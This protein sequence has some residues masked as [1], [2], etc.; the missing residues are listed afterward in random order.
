MKVGGTQWDLNIQ[1]WGDNS[2]VCR[3]KSIASSSPTVSAI[4]AYNKKNQ[5]LSA[6][7]WMTSS[8]SKIL[9][10]ESKTIFFLK[11]LLSYRT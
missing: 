10:M 8:Y 4:M 6:M 9:T 1:T 5:W 11:A 2:V 7:V 3:N